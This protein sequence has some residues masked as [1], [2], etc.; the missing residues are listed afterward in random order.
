VPRFRD[1][2]ALLIVGRVGIDGRVS[3]SGWQL[4]VLK[5]R[6]HSLWGIQTDILEAGEASVERIDEVGRGV[7]LCREPRTICDD[8]IETEL[9]GSLIGFGG[10]L[11]AWSLYLF[12]A[13]VDETGERLCPKC[14]MVVRVAPSLLNSVV[15]GASP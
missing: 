11:L 6:L 9:E 15:P 2:F 5:L 12:V 7:R 8:P 1:S 3:D 14:E 4:G 10:K 13:V